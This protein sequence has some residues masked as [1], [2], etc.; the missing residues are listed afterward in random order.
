MAQRCDSLQYWVLPNLF[1]PESDINSWEGFVEREVD[2][3]VC[4]PVK[5]ETAIEVW[6]SACQDW[7]NGL[8]E[9]PPL[10]VEILLSQSKQVS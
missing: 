4:I 3:C 6:P 8:R 7:I 10:L 2:E 5:N 1:G 9:L